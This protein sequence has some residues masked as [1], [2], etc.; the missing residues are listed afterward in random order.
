MNLAAP[1]RESMYAGL[2]ETLEHSAAVLA[3]LR[4]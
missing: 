4:A 3:A 1:R 2:R